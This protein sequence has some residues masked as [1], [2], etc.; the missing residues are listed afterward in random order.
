[1]AP[2]L[3]HSLDESCLKHLLT[4]GLDRGG[5]PDPLGPF[6]GTLQTVVFTDGVS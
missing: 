4:S 1:M 5:T 3:E 6:C 2:R